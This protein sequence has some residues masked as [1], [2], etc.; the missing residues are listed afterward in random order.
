MLQKV[1]IENHGQFLCRALSYKYIMF[2]TKKA[3]HGV[4]ASAATLGLSKEI[5]ANIIAKFANHIK[6]DFIV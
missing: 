3:T 5:I 1:H 4:A 2:A 6:D